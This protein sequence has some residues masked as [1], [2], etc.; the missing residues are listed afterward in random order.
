MFTSLV[1]VY[2]AFLVCLVIILAGTEVLVPSLPD[3]AVGPSQEELSRIGVTGS[4]FSRFGEVDKAAYA[5]VFFHAALV[6][7]VAAGLVG[8]LLGEGSLRDGIKHATAM[9][10]VAYVVFLVVTSPVASIAAAD[11]VSTGDTMTVDSVSLSDGGYV[12]VYDESV[13]GEILGRSAYLPPGTHEDV[14]V[15]LDKPID[16]ERRVF[17]FPH[18]E[19]PGD[20][21]FDYT[22]PPY[23][24]ET[25]QPDRPYTGSSR[26]G[27]DTV[28]VR[29][30]YVGE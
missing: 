29:V 16:R 2:I 3:T 19:T 6:Q 27:A 11:T 28:E 23:L 22:G 13:D 14:I 4:P 25:S 5:L 20:Q 30:R 26:S 8:G 1:V 10:A 21:S 15:R 17:L 7:G 9:L 18:R 24:P 12:V